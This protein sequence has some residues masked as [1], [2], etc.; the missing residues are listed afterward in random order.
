MAPNAI[1]RK[2]AAK[3]EAQ[4]KLTEEIAALRREQSAK[5]RAER[6][7]AERRIGRLAVKCGLHIFTREQLQP[8][9]QRA[10]KELREQV[11]NVRHLHDRSDSDEEHGVVPC[12]S[13]S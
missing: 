3:I 7:K 5:E 6:Q 10:E 12:A 2:M 13:M 8:V 9:F 11:E 1:D 4:Q